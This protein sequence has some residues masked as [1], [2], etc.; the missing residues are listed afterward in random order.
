L[1]TQPLNRAG[2]R[3]CSPFTA[4]S[5]PRTRQAFLR[6]GPSRARFRNIVPGYSILLDRPSASTKLFLFPAIISTITSRFPSL[7]GTVH[8]GPGALRS[9]PPPH[10]T[11]IRQSAPDTSTGGTC[12]D[13][14]VV[15]SSQISSPSKG[16]V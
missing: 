12:G 9:G 11:Q 13:A 8:P 3:N 10:A 1:T 15:A 2:P 14:I 16:V 7:A 5:A 6:Q 4:V